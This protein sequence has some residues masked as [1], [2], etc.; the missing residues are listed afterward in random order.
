MAGLL[1]GKQVK[2]KGS[3]DSA[4]YRSYGITWLVKG[5]DPEMKDGPFT[6]LQ[7]PGLPLPGSPWFFDNDFDPW[8]WC[9]PDMDIEALDQKKGE[10]FQWWTVSQ[11]FSN[12]PLS[13]NQ[14]R[15][16]DFRFDDPLMEPPKIQGS[17]VK[18]TREE[19][20]DRFNNPLVNSAWELIRGHAVEFDH[21]TDQIQ[22][23]QNVLDLNLP[24]LEAMRDT[25]NSLPIWGMPARCV[26]FSDFT[27]NP[28]FY[29][30]CYKYYV[31]KTVFDIDGET[32][33]K[34]ALDE[35]TKVLNG[36]W[37]Q[38]TKLWID[39]LV[40]G[41]PPDPKN[42]QHFI[43]FQDFNGNTTRTILDGFGRPYNPALS[44]TTNACSKC[45]S[46]APRI[47]N[48]TNTDTSFQGDFKPQRLIWSSGCLW[49]NAT[50]TLEW[51]EDFGKWVLTDTSDNTKW[52]ATDAEWDCMGPNFMNQ[53]LTID[54]DLDVHFNP[55]QPAGVMLAIG[56]PT[57]GV[58]HIE[59]YRESNFYD[60]NVPLIL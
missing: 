37:H 51:V 17:S 16:H 41:L 21:S 31:R 43:K 2:W 56:T 60:L 38:T 54:L 44:A 32:F 4:G 48:L 40:D 18:R 30:L 3:V 22:I 24:Q 1:V 55:D 25:V 45:P 5:T 52:S 28:Q 7:T 15:C 26:K 23:T 39:D 42:P 33:D 27:W 34:N 47:W 53:P 11:T 49:G 19:M 20:F 29:G 58:R 8:V 57:P 35:A 50:L 59:R 14:Q 13:F 9:R 10:R 46:G 12:K 6:I 36:H